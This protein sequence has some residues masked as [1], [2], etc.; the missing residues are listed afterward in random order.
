MTEKQTV[1]ERLEAYFKER[2]GLWLDGMEIARVAGCYGWRTRCSDLRKLGMTIENRQRRQTDTQGRR[3]TTS[4][5][6][7]VPSSPSV[8]PERAGHDCNGFELR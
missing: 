5:Y 3:W 7:Y 6:R 4:E 8:A 1:T 2:E